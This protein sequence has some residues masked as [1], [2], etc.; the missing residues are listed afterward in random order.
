MERQFIRSRSLNSYRTWK[1]MPAGFLRSMMVLLIILSSISDG[2]AQDLILPD[3][4][5]A[6]IIDQVDDPDPGYLFILSRPQ[7]PVKHPGYLSILDNYGTPVFYRYLSYQSGLFKVQPSGLL[8]FYKSDGDVKQVYL[9]DSA[10]QI[11]D[12]VWMEDYDLDTHDFIAMENGH[13]LMFGLELRSIDMSAIVDGGQV[14]A[15][16][17][18]CV[19]QE[20]DENKN[21][22]FEWNSFDHYLITDSNKDLTVSSLDYVHPNSL[23]IDTDGNILLI[24][25]AMNEITKIDRQ[26]GNII[27]RL[28]GK[29][30]QFTFADSTHM[31]SMPH[32]IR[33]VNNEGYYTLFDNGTKRNPSYTRGIEYLIDQESKTI[34]MVWEYDANKAVF[35]PSGGSTQRL[36]SG[37]TIMC[38]G[39]QVP[40][41]SV[42][43]VHPDGTVAFNLSFEDEN[44]R[45][46]NVVKQPWLTT[47]FT[48][49]TDT[50]N[51]GE[52]D[53]YTNSVY[54]LK[55]KNNSDQELDLTSYH[56]HTNAFT[57]DN[58]LF[59]MTLAPKEEKS[60][61]IL[62]Y[63]DDIESSEVSDVLSLN[64]D[65]NSDTLIQRVAVQV[66][67][68][69]TKIYSSVE[70][71]RP[72]GF[73]VYPNPAHDVI[74][75]S[76]PQK[77]VGQVCI[78][79][80]NGALLLNKTI[81][82]EQVTI[83]IGSLKR[84]MYL[85]EIS[86]SSTHSSYREKFVKL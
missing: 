39:G 40:N 68:S 5:P 43:E 17:K 49:N 71:N 21:V 2:R 63:P 36:P 44:F 23:E 41:P 6:F 14:D 81:N 9:M 65:I 38:Y 34:E 16:V 66:Q 86:N 28:G 4:F 62:Y 45:A 26:T 20:L 15:T 56:M 72:D 8:S 12:S 32:S 35:S 52:W 51:F 84:G 55:V 67:L 37:N 13:F 82:E 22:V 18:G 3:N 60:I 58:N 75:I 77:F 70:D 19:I 76:S 31:F 78:Y 53:G 42:T 1:K 25:R 69:G 46:G 11:V 50:V 61:N 29:N 59:P 33:K 30:N 48:T 7:T 27:W 54:I 73:S 83:D 64:S 24:A 74:H 10:F 57:I 85:I 47:L 79:A 80:V